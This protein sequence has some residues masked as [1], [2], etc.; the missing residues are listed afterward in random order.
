MNNNRIQLEGMRDVLESYLLNGQDI[1]G[2]IRNLE[3]LESG[4]EGM[5]DSWLAAF[6]KNWGQ[7][8]QVY[9]VAA[10]YGESVKSAEIRQ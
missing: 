3:I 2:L 8:E 4:L 9:S 7:L 1:S 6:K 5:T 10:A